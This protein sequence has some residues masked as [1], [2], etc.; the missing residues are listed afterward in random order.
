MAWKQEAQVQINSK[1]DL[2]YS[3]TATGSSISLS[4]QLSD[5]DLVSVI[6]SDNDNQHWAETLPVSACNLMMSFASG[7]NYCRF[8]YNS[9]NNQLV[10]NNR[11]GRWITH[12]YGIKLGS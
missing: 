7:Q 8:S 12:V 5:Y 4:K 6:M 11:V 10:Y 2:L 9:A 1:M 3:G